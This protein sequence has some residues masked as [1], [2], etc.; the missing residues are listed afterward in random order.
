MSMLAKLSSA[1]KADEPVAF[2]GVDEVLLSVK[3][4]LK[5]RAAVNILPNARSANVEAC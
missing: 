1:G 2:A 4:R 3:K 5:A